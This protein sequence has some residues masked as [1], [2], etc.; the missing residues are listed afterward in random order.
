M[1]KIWTISA[2]QTFEWAQRRDFYTKTIQNGI[3]IDWIDFERQTGIVVD[4][5]KANEK[6][7]VNRSFCSE[8]T[9]SAKR[10]I[11]EVGGEVEVHTSKRRRILRDSTSLHMT[12]GERKQGI[13]GLIY[14]QVKQVQYQLKYLY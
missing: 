10:V 13:L 3:P 1:I 2:N 4:P 12:S 11:S 8:P 9:P 7:D 5:A 6:V 14:N